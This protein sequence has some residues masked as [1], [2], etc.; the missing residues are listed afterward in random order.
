MVE[1][2]SV[3]VKLGEKEY[4]VQTAGFIRA[5]PWKKRLLE[6]IKP[7]FERLNDAPNIEFNSAADLFKLFP[8]VE[9]V[10]ING[11]DT[12]FGLLIAYSPVLETDKEYIEAHASDKQILAAFQEAVKLSD[13][14]G[15]VAQMNRKL[16]L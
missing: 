13:P 15:L 14:F 10:F 3:T 5:R 8:L 12:V 2:E 6:E 7:L 1:I 9:D 11:L 4:T 16:G